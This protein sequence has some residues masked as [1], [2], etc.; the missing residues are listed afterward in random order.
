MKI[1]RFGGFDNNIDD[2]RV[3]LFVAWG[4]RAGLVSVPSW[5]GSNCPLKKGTGAILSLRGRIQ[6]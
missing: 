1:T 2:F 3:D 4:W 6:E 5:V